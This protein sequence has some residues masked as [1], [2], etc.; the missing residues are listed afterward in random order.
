MANAADHKT[1]SN[2]SAQTSFTSL[3]PYRLIQML[4]MGGMGEVWRA[5]QTAP[6]HRIVALKLIKAGMDTRA[7]GPGSSPS[8]R[9]WRSWNIPISLKSSTPEARRKDALISSWNTCPASP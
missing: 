2:A 5:E 4:G 6:F 3:G 9:P 8:V 7:V 1:L